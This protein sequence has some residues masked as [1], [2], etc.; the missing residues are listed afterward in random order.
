MLIVM[1]LWILISISFLFS[2]R[3]ADFYTDRHKAIDI[4]TEQAMDKKMRKALQKIAL[5][6]NATGTQCDRSVLIEAVVEKL[7]GTI[8]RQFGEIESW[9]MGVPGGYIDAEAGFLIGGK[10]VFPH[11]QTAAYGRARKIHSFDCCNPV[12]KVNGSFASSDKFSLFIERS[13]VV[14]LATQNF[15]YPKER[16]SK[17]NGQIETKDVN[18]WNY[19]SKARSLLSDSRSELNKI[20][21]GNSEASPEAKIQLIA[22]E[23]AKRLESRGQNAP[24]FSHGDWVATWEGVQFWR[25][26]TEGKNSIKS[27]IGPGHFKCVGEKWVFADNFSWDQYVNSGW[28]EG[29]NCND[30]GDS[31][32]GV[33]SDATSACPKEPKQCDELRRKYSGHLAPLIHRNCHSKPKPE[34]VLPTGVEG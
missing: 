28:D 29:I 8:G 11:Q 2:E 30:Y 21:Q 16:I 1:F 15:L 10:S 17:I 31:I 5:E 4:N 22:V 20:I 9:S 26:L 25:R 23:L 14:Y 32:R 24:I 18:A 6:V 19:M 3:E 12:F 13:L 7:G 34:E 27:S 33:M